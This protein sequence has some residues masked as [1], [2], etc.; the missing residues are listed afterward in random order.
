MSESSSSG[1]SFLLILLALGGGI[2]LVQWLLEEPKPAAQTAPAEAVSSTSSRAVEFSK[3]NGEA[4]NNSMSEQLKSVQEMVGGKI[5]GQTY[6][7]PQG[8]K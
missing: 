7:L 5:D 8:K 2:W 6:T 1:T 4:L 3:N